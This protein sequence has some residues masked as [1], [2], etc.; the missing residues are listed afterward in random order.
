MANDVY[1]DWQIKHKLWLGLK[2]WNELSK[3]W[4]MTCF[5]DI[6]VEE[7]TSKIE[8]FSKM[9]NLCFLNL[10]G[11]KMAKL[12]KEKVDSL[13]ATIPVVTYLRDEAL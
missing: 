4:L 11:S 10:K 13:K 9:S 6:D 12:F 5:V 8:K 1:E 2:I 3:G 7:I